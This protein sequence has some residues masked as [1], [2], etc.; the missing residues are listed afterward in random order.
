MI[1]TKCSDFYCSQ[2]LSS[3]Y[4]LLFKF[5]K[6]LGQPVDLGRKISLSAAW[7]ITINETFHHK[8]FVYEKV[9]FRDHSL[10]YSSHSGHLTNT[11]C[12]VLL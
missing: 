10:V 1:K 12:L 6:Q 2:T 7:V 8:A 9:L 5:S 11:T 3:N 4:F